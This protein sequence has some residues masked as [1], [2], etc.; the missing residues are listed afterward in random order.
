MI[1]SGKWMDLEKIKGNPDLK[2]QM[3]NVLS[4]LGFLASSLP[5]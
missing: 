1:F 5:M 2:R 4:H 3:L